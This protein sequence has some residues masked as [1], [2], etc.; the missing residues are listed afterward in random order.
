[1]SPENSTLY[2]YHITNVKFLE[3]LICFCTNVIYLYI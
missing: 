3:F 2:T 1:M